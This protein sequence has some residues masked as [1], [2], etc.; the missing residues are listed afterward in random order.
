MIRVEKLD[1]WFPRELKEITINK[2]VKKIVEITKVLCILNYFLEIKWLNQLYFAV[3]W[4]NFI[5]QLRK[6]IPDLPKN[7]RLLIRK[8]FH[9]LD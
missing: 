7:C 5:L 1:V 9:I 4:S 2:G 3:N 6:K 8:C